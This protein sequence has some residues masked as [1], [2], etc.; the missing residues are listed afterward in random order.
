MKKLQNTHQNVEKFKAFVAS[1]HVVI[2]LQALATVMAIPE[3]FKRTNEFETLYGVAQ[4]DGEKALLEKFKQLINDSL[5]G[6][7]EKLSILDPQ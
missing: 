4:F 7:A 1:E 5:D 6:N 3:T 2:V